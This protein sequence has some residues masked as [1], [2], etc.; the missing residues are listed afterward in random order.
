MKRNLSLFLSNKFDWETP[1]ELFVRLDNHFDFTVDAAAN[2]LNAKLPRFWTEEENGLIMPWNGER[3]Y[4]NPPYGTKQKA[5]V[6]KAAEHAAE[7]SV[8]LLPARPDTAVW[9]D[10]IF[11]HAEV[12]FLRGRIKFISGKGKKQNA[13]FP[14][15]LAIFRDRPVEKVTIGTWD[16]AAVPFY[17]HG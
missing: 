13:P 2:R 1:P 8:L 4:C 6:E 10:L 7:V 9:H 11:P 5:F 17:Q 3:V 16:P 12:I 14:S 15:A